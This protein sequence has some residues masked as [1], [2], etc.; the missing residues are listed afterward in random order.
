MAKTKK[1]LDI[2]IQCEEVKARRK[3]MSKAHIKLKRPVNKANQEIFHKLMEV[4]E[5]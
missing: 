5:E 2:A 4:Y 1:D 3:K